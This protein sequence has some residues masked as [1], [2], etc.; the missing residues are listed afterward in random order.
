MKARTVLPALAAATALLTGSPALAADACVGTAGPGAARLAV[1]VNG[2]RPIR[3]EVAVTVYPN[4]RK[5]FLAPGGK[6]LRQRVRAAAVSTACF[7]L[8]PGQYAVAV[9]HDAN[10]NDDFDR[11]LVGMPAEGFGFSND[12]PTR[13]GLPPLEAVRFRLDAGDPPVRIQLRYMR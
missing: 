11:T 3:G 12:A 10:N 6:L 9:Y 8:P 7:W 4:S 5:R 1:E 2:A 13:V